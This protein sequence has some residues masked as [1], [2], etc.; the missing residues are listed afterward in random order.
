SARGV[1]A[2]AALRAGEA[3]VPRVPPARSA[4]PGDRALP[5]PRH[6][7]DDHARTDRQGLRN[8]LRRQRREAAVR[9]RPDMATFRTLAAR[10]SVGT[11]F[12]VLSW[13]FLADFMRTG[14]LTGLLFLASE[15][16]VVILTIVRR[17]AQTV[18]RSA[19]AAALTALSL[20]GP[21][22]VRP[23]DVPALAP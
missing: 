4:R 18:D 2:E 16:L 3:S 1:P 12:F 8:V 13:N 5:V 6:R 11:L 15:A 10:A 23:T 19:M 14:R 9:Y 20:L 17:R 21:P 7:A 22:L